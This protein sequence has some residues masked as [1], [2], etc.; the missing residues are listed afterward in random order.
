MCLW[1]GPSTGSVVC[2]LG[3]GIC[4]PDSLG[5]AQQRPVQMVTALLMCIHDTKACCP[6]PRS[7]PS[8]CYFQRQG[9]SSA[10]DDLSS[11]KMGLFCA[12]APDLIRWHKQQHTAPR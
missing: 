7:S 5:A 1:A 3:T 4:Q 2:D 8:R 9:D 11:F 6:K 10:L 12:A